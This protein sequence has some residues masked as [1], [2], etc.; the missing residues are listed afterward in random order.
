M[1]V[2]LDGQ[3]EFGAGFSVT[4]N[5]TW[6][7]GELDVFPV[8]GSSSAVAEP[9]S[10]L[11]PFTYNLGMRWDSVDGDYWLSCNATVAAKADRLS[12]ADQQD[13]QRI[14]P[15][16]TPGYTLVNLQAGG[17]INDH[18]TAVLGIGNVFDEAYR[19]HGSGSNEPG[20]GIKLGLEASF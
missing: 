4:G 14:P 16:G 3:L 10:R 6:L 2:E 17:V 1:G 7:R 12:S 11:T 19:S 20:R 18:L 5:I 13:L 8:T 9:F 15:G